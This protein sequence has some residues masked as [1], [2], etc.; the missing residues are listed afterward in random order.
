MP[1][2]IKFLHFLS[3]AWS[4]RQVKQS[5]RNLQHIWFWDFCSLSRQSASSAARL[6]FYYI[7]LHVASRLVLCLCKC[8]MARHEDMVYII[9]Y[10]QTTQY[11]RISPIWSLL[12]MV[13]STFLWHPKIDPRKTQRNKPIIWLNNNTKFKKH[14]KSKGDW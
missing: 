2:N 14:N 8:T 12:Y 9:F 1:W 13:Q 11:T 3:N 6:D 10:A 4:L 7:D 5:A